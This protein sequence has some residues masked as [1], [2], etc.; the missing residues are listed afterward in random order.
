MRRTLFFITFCLFLWNSLYSQTG[1]EAR[2][3]LVFTNSFTPKI[4]L[5]VSRLG[6]NISDLSYTT[7][8]HSVAGNKPRTF[9]VINSTTEFRYQ[10]VMLDSEVDAYFPENLYAISLN[11][12]VLQSLN[13]NWFLYTTGTLGIFSDL[14]NVNND[15]LLLEGGIVPVYWVNP[16]LAI[17]IGPV[18]TYAFGRPRLLPLPYIKTMGEGT[19]RFSISI[20]PPSEGRAGY[21]FTDLLNVGF[22]A[23]IFRNTYELGD[24]RAITAGSSPALVFSD[25]SLGPDVIF[26]LAQDVELRFHTG[27]TV[28]RQFEIQQRGE[29]LFSINFENTFFLSTSLTAQF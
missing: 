23:G 27:S 6:Y 24:A 2:P 8:L 15:H 22:A 11:L 28:Y 13:S 7:N 25:W 26:T 20:I 12:K 17:G 9:T 14:E 16:E 21:Q 19:S 29:S 4:D 1:M 5:G 3:K 18:Y 10:R